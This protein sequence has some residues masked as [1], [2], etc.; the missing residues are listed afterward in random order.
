MH[1]V[2]YKR[3]DTRSKVIAQAMYEGVLRSGDKASLVDGWKYETGHPTGDVAIFYGY[4]SN[5]REIF[6]D[7]LAAGKHVIFIDLGYWGRRHGGRY[8]GFH[9]FSVDSRHPS[10]HVM[11]KDMPAD[12]LNVLRTLHA[13]DMK[14]PK[15][16][17]LITKDTDFEVK[18]WHKNGEYIVL[19]GMQKKSC[20]SYKLDYMEW[21]TKAVNILKAHSKRPIVY[22]PKPK[23]DDAREIP[24]T[25]FSGRD[26]KLAKL[27]KSAWAIVTHHS[28]VAVDAVVE[29]IPIFCYDGIA[30]PMGSDDLTKIE[31]PN[32]TGN[33][34]Q[35]LQNAC[36]FQFSIPEMREGV[37]W[38]T[39][40]QMGIL[41]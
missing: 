12:R 16:L 8:T 15:P 10:N 37:P 20:D 32:L 38:R 22:R 25:I 24:G 1:A 36:Y 29:G 18:P 39:F 27:F 5:G 4:K 13:A 11:K 31:T 26:E 28:N 30:K 6:N 35:W 33:R 41:G 21:E 7:Y 14:L 19:A 2:C 40:K 34:Q 3:T 17:G 23:D 9:R